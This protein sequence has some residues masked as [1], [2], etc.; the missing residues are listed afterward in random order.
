[1]LGLATGARESIS[2][3]VRTTTLISQREVVVSELFSPPCLSLIE[4]SVGHEVDQIS[5]VDNNVEGFSG[6]Y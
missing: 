2:C 3:D 6:T 1:M 4:N 5:V